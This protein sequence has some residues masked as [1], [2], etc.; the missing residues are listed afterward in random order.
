MFVTGTSVVPPQGFENSPKASF[1]HETQSKFPTAS[2]CGLWLRVPTSHGSSYSKFKEC[3]VVA[4][5]G[6]NGFA[7]S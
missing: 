5:K 1:L 3:M 6:N 7:F 4:I 2:T